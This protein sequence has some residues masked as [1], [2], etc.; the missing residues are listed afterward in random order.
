MGYEEEIK[1]DK[2]YVK[3]K[4]KKVKLKI[5]N[6]ID[7]TIDKEAYNDPSKFEIHHNND[8]SINMIIKHVMN[9]IEK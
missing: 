6:D 5:D 8:G 3:K 1:L 4:L 9:Y 7:L 2:D